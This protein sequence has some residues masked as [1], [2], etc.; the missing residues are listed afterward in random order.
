MT[1]Y[2]MYFSPT[3]TTRKIAEAMASRL[4]ELKTPGKAFQTIDF[5][6]KN[7]REGEP[8]TFTDDDWV[9]FGLPTIAGRVPNV[10]L[11]YLDTLKGNGT[12]AVSLVLYGNRAYD[13]SLIELSDILTNKGFW[14]AAGAA[15]I[16]EHSFS[17][18]LAQGRPDEEDLV[19]ARAFA[20]QIAAKLLAEGAGSEKGALPVSVKGNRPYRDYYRP[21]DKNGNPVDI[22]KVV[23]LT[24]DTCTD[25][26][27][28]VSV[29][30]MDSIDHEDP[31]KMVGICI[32]CGACLKV[33][34]VEAKYYDDENYLKHKRELEEELTDRKQ[35]ELFV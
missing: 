21:K 20:G 32:K 15:F 16:G 12:T 24:L 27:E 2:A 19:T 17:K 6:L 4:A 33:C 5:T 29:C 23:P 11:K 10:L 25:C 14:V 26:K 1:V 3:G 35:P 28:C 18:T 30:P 8:A 31:K 34:P 9:V 22:R 13:D 7:K